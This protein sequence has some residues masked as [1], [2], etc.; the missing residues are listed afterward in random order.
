MKKKKYIMSGGT[1]F[2]EKEDL[3][4]LSDYA[5]K[6]WLLDRFAFLGYTLKKGTPQDLQY[7]LDFQENADDEY[8]MLFQEAGWQHVCSAGHAMHIFSAPEGTKPIYSDVET[9]I[10]RYKREK[11]SVGKAALS[12]LA[13][14]VFLLLFDVMSLY[15]WF[16]EAV[17]TISDI[18]L[19]IST[20]L[21]VFPG[22]PYFAYQRKLKKLGNI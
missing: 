11:H 5:K 8:F 1:A 10:D 14:M 15:G 7:S 4:K 22:L 21:L 9:V 3:Q 13:V 17:G 6:G 2:A 12:I 20:V 16:P 19:I 18:L